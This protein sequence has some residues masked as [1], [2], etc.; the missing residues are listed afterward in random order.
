MWDQKNLKQI[1][2]K[3]KKQTHRYR[4]QTSGYQQGRGDGEGQGR[5]IGLRY[6]CYHV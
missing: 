3:K 6:T 5:Y 1:N 2:L 4:G